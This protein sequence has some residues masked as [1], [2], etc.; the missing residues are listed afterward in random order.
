M[1]P[2]V[3][4]GMPRSYLSNALEVELLLNEESKNLSFS[5]SFMS[6]SAVVEADVEVVPSA[7]GYP[8]PAN[9]VDPELP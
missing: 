6:L 4:D 3:V 9:P 8:D 7:E 2:P 1:A 5:K